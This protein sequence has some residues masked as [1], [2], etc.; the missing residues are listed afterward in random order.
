MALDEAT[1]LVVTE[2]LNNCAARS[3]LSFAACLIDP[4]LTALSIEDPTELVEDDSSSISRSLS[5][6]TGGAWAPLRL[7]DLEDTVRRR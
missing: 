4:V 3:C 6:E 1:F 5:E 7:V 2:P